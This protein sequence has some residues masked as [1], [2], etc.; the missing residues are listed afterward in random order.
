MPPAGRPRRACLLRAAGNLT[1]AAV[2]HIPSLLQ[3]QMQVPRYSR[4][5]RQ[6][7]FNVSREEN[8]V[9]THKIVIEDWQ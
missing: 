3:V 4:G 2:A 1:P 6:R 5:L 9:E 8:W 7:L